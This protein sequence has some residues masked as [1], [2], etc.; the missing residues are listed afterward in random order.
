MPGE[1]IIIIGLIETITIYGK[2]KNKKIKAKIDTGAT[3]SSI[4][5]NLASELHLGP[6][7]KSKMVKSAH[8]SR[9]RPVIECEINLAK[10]KII[11]EFT[12]AD[13]DHMKYKVLVGQNALK[14]YFLIDPSKNPK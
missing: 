14:K 7:I 5:L 3:K 4:D 8:G 12:L 2:K 10:K 6:I 11:S 13:R 9:V 1:R